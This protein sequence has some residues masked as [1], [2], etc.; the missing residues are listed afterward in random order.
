MATR[1]TTNQ[2][3]HDLDIL[4]TQRNAERVDCSEKIKKMWEMLFGNGKDGI[5]KRLDRVEQLVCDW[6]SDL[7]SIRLLIY[8]SIILAILGLILK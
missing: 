3:Q 4:I 7:K 2:L 8:S 5:D 1:S 6:K